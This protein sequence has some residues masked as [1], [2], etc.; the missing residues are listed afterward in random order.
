MAEYENY[1]PDF[2]EVSRRVR[3]EIASGVCQTVGCNAIHGEPHP[4]FNYIVT[5]QTAH[6][7]Q[8]PKN[9]HPDNLVALCEACHFRL[10]DRAN[11]HKRKYGKGFDSP[12]QMS[13]V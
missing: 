13:L 7:D 8:N 6:K 11:I 9:D 2:K 1:N 5:L 12:D 10:D 3:F 4:R